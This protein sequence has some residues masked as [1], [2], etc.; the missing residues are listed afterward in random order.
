MA[1]RERNKGIRLDNLQVVAR[2]QAW[3]GDSVGKFSFPPSIILKTDDSKDI[4]L[5]EAELLWDSCCVTVH[6]TSC[7]SEVR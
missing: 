4:T 2:H 3:M 6:C 7:N 5:V 1:V